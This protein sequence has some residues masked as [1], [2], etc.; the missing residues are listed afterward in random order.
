MHVLS[1]AFNRSE[2]RSH[3]LQMAELHPL[4][5]NASKRSP[6]PLLSDIGE[7]VNSCFWGSAFAICVIPRVQRKQAYGK[8]IGVPSA[9]RRDVFR[10]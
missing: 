4:M 7:G 8:V 5:G 6:S 3:H 9:V 1:I 2:S 10:L